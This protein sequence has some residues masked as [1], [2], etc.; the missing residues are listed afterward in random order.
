MKSLAPAII[1][2][3]ILGALVWAFNN[4]NRETNVTTVPATDSGTPEKVVVASPVATITFNGLGFS[5]SAVSV[6]SGD[7][8]AIKNNSSQTIEFNSNPHPIHTD[9][10][11]LN[12]GRI[13]PG[14][15]LSVKLTRKGAW[16][17]HDHLNSSRV[18]TITVN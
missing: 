15:T 16:G 5:L 1:A 11:E 10:S 2:L 13:P 12:V 14:E 4:E 8:I 18:G 6:K 7:T 9:N 3:A 17:Y